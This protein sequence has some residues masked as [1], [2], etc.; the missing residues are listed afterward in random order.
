METR[1]SVALRG[2]FLDLDMLKTVTRRVHQMEAGPE[3]IRNSF[4]T[5]LMNGSVD[6]SETS[7]RLHQIKLARLVPGAAEAVGQPLAA[8]LTVIGRFTLWKP[9]WALML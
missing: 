8:F 9:G 5:H 3:P 6:P 2:R 4:D 7:C 1:A